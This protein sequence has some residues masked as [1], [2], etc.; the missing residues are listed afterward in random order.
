M[1]DKYLKPQKIIRSLFK[2]KELFHKEMAEIPFDEKIK[3]LVNLQKIVKDMGR[4]S[5][6]KQIVWKI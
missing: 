3:I 2:A 4:P 5:K 1:K 6:E